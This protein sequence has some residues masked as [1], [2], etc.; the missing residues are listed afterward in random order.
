[1]REAKMKKMNAVL[2]LIVLA[3]SPAVAQGVSN[4]RDANGNLPRDKGVSASSLRTGAQVSSGAIQPVRSTR[5]K[6]T[7]G[8]K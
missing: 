7:S 2:V 5:T 8:S 4:A 1:M 3:T 6:P